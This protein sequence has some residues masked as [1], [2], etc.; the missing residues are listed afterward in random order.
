METYARKVK[1]PDFGL[2]VQVL[3]FEKILKLQ[4]FLTSYSTYVEQQM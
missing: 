3:F 2:D 4:Y 1:A